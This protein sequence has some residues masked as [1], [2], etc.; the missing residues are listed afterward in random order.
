[1]RLRFRVMTT[2]SRKAGRLDD[3]IWSDDQDEARRRGIVRHGNTHRLRASLVLVVA[4]VAL[5]LG[6]AALISA[7]LVRTYEVPSASMSPTIKPNTRVSALLLDTSAHRGDILVFHAPPQVQ[8]IG[9]APTALIKRAVAI[10][11]DTVKCCQRD[12]I[13]INGQ[14]MTEPYAM[15]PQPPFGPVKVPVG[16]LF[17][18]GDNRSDSQDSK[19]YGPISTDLVVGHVIAQGAAASI[20]SPIVL[21]AAFALVVTFLA[22]LLGVRRMSAWQGA[23]TAE[24]KDG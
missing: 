3:P 15:G 9:L 14:P 17:V 23:R 2:G 16:R 13:V 7:I 11:G 22:W 19:F 24:A 1:M 20:L 21:G 12:R 6:S 4:F 5:W 8:S 18:L 10:G